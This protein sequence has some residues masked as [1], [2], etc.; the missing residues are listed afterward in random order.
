MK[1]NKLIIL[2]LICFCFTVKSQSIYNMQGFELQLKPLMEQMFS[3]Q[4]DNERFNANEKFMS[5]ME[6]AL[7]GQKSF[8][9][10]F[11]S[12]DKIKILTSKDKVFRIFTW[13][14]VNQNGEYDNFGFVQSK[15]R[16]SGD[17]EVYRLF[18]KSDEI[19]MPEYEKLN[20]STW[21]G[22]V[23]YELITT[24]NQDNTYYTLLGWD[25]NNIY[26]KRKL[27]EPITFAK[28]SGRP[29]FGQNVFYKDKN[30]RRY[31]FEYSPKAYFNLQWGNQFFTESNT[32]R[33]VKSTLFRKAKPFEVEAPK[34]DKKQMIFFDV[35]EPA[36]DNMEGLKQN[37]VP[38]G[39]V[40][41]FYFDNGRWKQIKD[42]VPRNKSNNKDK[43]IQE[44]EHNSTLFPSKEKK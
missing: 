17:Y 35:L 16:T 24:K 33:K 12:L 28:N 7:E 5:V 4:T 14:I 31:I 30:R 26:T 44:K 21:F 11:D 22:A 13:A 27:I 20:D 29:I 38:S 23:Y 1:T 32:R 34:M 3:A 10:P 19:A 37:Y 2:F 39:E 40:D 18:D 36:V 43:Y 6:D 15:N 42:I 9:Y 41:G 25:G 8:S